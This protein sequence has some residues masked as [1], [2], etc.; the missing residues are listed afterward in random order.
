[1]PADPSSLQALFAEMK[2]RRV[3]KV[4]AVYG[5]VAFVLLQVADIAFEPLGLPEWTMTLVLFL[6]ML[7]LPLAIVLA[8]A[9]E[10]T[11]GGMRRTA[12]APEDEIRQMVA[13]PPSR[14]WPAG[15]RALASMILLFGTGW[16]MGG[17][18][19]GDER[20][21]NLVSTAQA[22][23]LRAIAALPFD[24]VN[25]T[26]EN[27]LIAVGIHDDLLTRLSRIGDLRVTSRTSVRD[28]EGTDATLR[29]I[30]DQLGVEYILEGSVRSSG[31][32]VRVSVSLVDLSGG[33]ADEQ[34]LWSDQY[35]H[36]VTPENLFDIQAEI[37]EAVVGAL[38]AQLTPEEAEVLDAMRPA[39]SSVAQQWYYRGIEA[40]TEGNESIVEARDA[41]L[42][43]VELDSTYAAA[44]SQLA[45]FESR[46]AWLG[47]D[48]AA[49]AEAAM[50]RTERLAPG[51]VEAHLARGFFEY[52][53]QQNFDAALSAFRAAERQAPSDADVAVAIGL[54]L[55]RQ[56]DWD[57]S[58]A[59]MRR[60]V[61]LDPRNLDPLQFLG[62]VLAFRGA[63]RAA[64]AVFDR[65]LSVDPGNPEIRGRKVNN[66]A[67]LDR[68][69]DRARRLADELA[70]DRER[71][72]E[73]IVL[74]E[75][76][77]FDRDFA[78]AGEALG[79][80]RRSTRFLIRSAGWMGTARYA[81]FAADPASAATAA[82][83]AL[84]ALDDGT[85]K[86]VVEEAFRGLAHALADRP[87]EGLP[88][89]ER[90]ER[91]IR[92]WE[93]HVDP[94]RWGLDVVD[95]YGMM[96]E[97][98]R[99]F[100]LLDDLVDRPSTDLS[101]ALLELDPRFDPY[102]DDPHFDELI[103]RRGRFEADAA[104]W[105]EANGPWLP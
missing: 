25:G 78:R 33:A 14:R 90:A 105:A 48:R 16:Y 13:E 43:A 64:D 81:R 52:Y 93:D 65:G 82:D 56:G 76:A 80:W 83:S 63:F 79:E 5:A 60:A 86:E 20:A 102:R 44:W 98:D 37:A 24:D 46:L 47:E 12:P 94:T 72:E 8:W 4:M 35:D 54:I 10:S 19:W 87:A 62:E 21:I 84:A 55:R 15:L 7:G 1:M 71:L 88:H 23:D 69:P 77:R 34:V 96:N 73:S 31:N 99:G 36:E 9:F 28:Y 29:D 11:P 95:G 41:M 53:A 57:G 42:R 3:F 26:D 51:S 50:A 101:V 68:D 103:E 70:L 85:L 30:A 89:L 2:R 39:G 40:W 74:A 67:H 27:R 32:Q 59:A 92:S 17:G 18:G 6:A 75:L 91:L 66:L 104:A 49:Q 58:A 38:E 45:K 61:V 97:L 100:D 22:S